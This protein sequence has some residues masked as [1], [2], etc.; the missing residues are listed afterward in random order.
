MINTDIIHPEVRKQMWKFI[1]IN[2]KNPQNSMII[3]DTPLIYETDLHTYLDFVVVVS[4]STECCIQRVVK[5]NNLKR[6]EILNRMKN[7]ISLSE[8]IR[9]ADFHIKND[10]D[11]AQLKSQVAQVY[12]KIIS[13]W[14]TKINE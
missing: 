2:Q 11:T 9:R 6:S 8:K 5:R 12:Q 14:R 10:H 13:K 3:V 1:A 7:Q 4:A